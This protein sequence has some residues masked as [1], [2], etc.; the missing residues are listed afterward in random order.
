MVLGCSDGVGPGVEPIT[1]LPRP[2]TSAELSVI[3]ASN[4]FGAELLRRVVAGDSRDNVVISPLS[5]SMALGMTLNGAASTTFAGMATALGFGGLTQEEINDSYRGLIDLLTD[6]DPTVTFEIANAIWANEGFLF[7]DSFFQ[8]VSTAFDAR[9]ET[10]DFGDPATV[11]AINDWVD[12][13]THGL[14]DSI[15]DAL[16]PALVMLLVN[17]IYYEAEW[18]LRFD[19]AETRPAPFTR[20]DGTAVTVDMMRLDDPE[21]RSSRGPEYMAVELPYGGGPFTMLVI[22]PTGPLTARELV[23]D[24]DA[25]A[26]GTLVGGLA[27]A[28]PAWVAIPKFTLTYD[29]FLNEALKDMG[30]AEAF[31]PGADFTNLSPLGDQLC[32]SY[33]RQKTYV[34]LYERGTRAAAVT[35]V[36]VGVTSAPSGFTADRPFVF[37]I[38]E[39]L[40]GSIL[41]AGLVGDPTAADEGPESQSDCG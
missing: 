39:R 34:E 14:I 6:L 4:H 11:S 31:G 5:A 25:G 13:R 9:A 32:I 7:R 33:V 23:A 3:G 26:W 10:R 19:P 17:A 18:T 40:S 22:V 21:V 27:D 16:D 1:E 38:R 15:V 2:L 35:S 28:N 30:M 12:G 29:G 20:D 37:A 8:A 36:G 41:F 24:L